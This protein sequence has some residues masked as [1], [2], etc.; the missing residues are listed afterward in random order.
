MTEET[1][2]FKIAQHQIDLVAE[3]LS[4]K[5]GIHEFLRWPQRELTV[6]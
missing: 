1:N 2:P 4:L 5:K 3:K 6:K